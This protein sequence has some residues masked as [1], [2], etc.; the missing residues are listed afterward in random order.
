MFKGLVNQTAM[1]GVRSRI[2]PKPIPSSPQRKGITMSDQ[3]KTI[4]PEAAGD[5]ILRASE[6]MRMLSLGRTAFYDAV[7]DPAFPRPVALG[8]RAR[9]WLQSEILAWAKA[10][11]V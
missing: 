8:A 4:I 3:P 1:F 7:K 6:A 10:R 11:R 2:L 5:R 9:G